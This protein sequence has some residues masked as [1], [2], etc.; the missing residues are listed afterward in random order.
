M[1]YPRGYKRG[2]L[3]QGVCNAGYRKSEIVWKK[4]VDKTQLSDLKGMFL[5]KLDGLG[6]IDD[7]PFID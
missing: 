4:G 2:A 5:Q 1:L 3:Y 7:R 6:P